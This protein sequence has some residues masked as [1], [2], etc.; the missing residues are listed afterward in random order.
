MTGNI[1]LFIPASPQTL[2]KCSEFTTAKTSQAIEIS[3]L[4]YNLLG[5][6][7]KQYVLHDY[8]S[9]SRSTHGQG[10]QLPKRYSVDKNMAG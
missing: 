2:V 3:Q 5:S 8:N 10:R 7:S 4:H 9:P 1:G 6:P